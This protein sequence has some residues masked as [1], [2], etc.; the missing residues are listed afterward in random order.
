MKSLILSSLTAKKWT[1]IVSSLGLG[2][3]ISLV[4]GWGQ[5]SLAQRVNPNE[6]EP[7][8]SNEVDSFGGGTFGDALNPFDLIHNNNIGPGRSAEDFQSDTNKSLDDATAEF[9]RLQQERWNNQ[10][11]QSEA[12]VPGTSE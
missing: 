7:Y 9:R 10:N 8:Q 6:P 4:A 12:P 11:Q 1:R 5:V 2:T 3:V